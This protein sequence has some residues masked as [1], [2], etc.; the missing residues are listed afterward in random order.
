MLTFRDHVIAADRDAV[1]A[2]V[3]ATGMFRPNEVDVAVEL[4]DERL[5]KGPASGY[6]F[7]LACDGDCVI[8]YACY[9]HISIT[10]HSYDLYWIVVDPAR[11][12]QGL[13][14]QLL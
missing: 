3:C 13:G 7:V 4:V 6:E 8:G 10:L 2:L 12:G 5:Q 14:R 11:Q 1:R 9:G